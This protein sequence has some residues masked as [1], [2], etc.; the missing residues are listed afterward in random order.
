MA[1]DYKVEEL[2]DV[3][4]GEPKYEITAPLRDD[5]LG[6]TLIG[7]GAIQESIFH[8]CLVE[9]GPCVRFRVTSPTPMFTWP[10]IHK[11]QTIFANELRQARKLE[12]MIEAIEMASKEAKPG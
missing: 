2:K 3:K 4:A 7:V 8:F 9:G 5:P 6:K 11:A 12:K 10:E 1:E